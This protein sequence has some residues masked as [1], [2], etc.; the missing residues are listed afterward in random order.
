MVVHK[1]NEVILEKKKKINWSV[2]QKTTK[3][4][5]DRV[6][7]C[8]FFL[9]E[10][11]STEPQAVSDSARGF[12]VLSGWLGSA[13]LQ[14]EGAHRQS[15]ELCANVWIR[16]LYCQEMLCPTTWRYVVRGLLDDIQY[17]LFWTLSFFNLCFCAT[18]LSN[19]LV[20]RAPFQPSSKK[21]QLQVPYFKDTDIVQV[22]NTSCHL[23]K[24]HLLS[25]RP[26][27]DVRL[28]CALPGTAFGQWDKDKHLFWNTAG[29]WERRRWRGERIQQQLQCP[30]RDLSGS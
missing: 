26:V 17:V 24:T 1:K 5:T 8:H 18:E 6:F 14:C 15:Q 29:W 23:H 16:K 3:T 2:Q 12:E 10:W 27:C 13:V 22:R 11:L 21:T 30:K 19:L 28:W 20:M 7:T 9:I 4:K 25:S